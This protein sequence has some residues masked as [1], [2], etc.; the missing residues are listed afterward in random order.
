MSNQIVYQNLIQ[1]DLLY[2]GNA[3]GLTKAPSSLTPGTTPAIGAFITVDTSTVAPGGWPNGTTLDWENG[4]SA[5]YVELSPNDIIDSAFLFWGAYFGNLGSTIKD[6]PIYLITPDSIKHTITPDYALITNARSYSNVSDVTNILTGYTSGDYTVGS[7]PCA[8]SPLATDKQ[9]GGWVLALITK[10]IISAYNYATLCLTND[11]LLQIGTRIPII[12]PSNGAVTG[13]LMFAALGACATKGDALIVQNTR[14]FLITGRPVGNICCSLI[15]DNSAT[16]AINTK[17]TFGLNNNTPDTQS[18]IINGRQGLDLAIFPPNNAIPS[19]S[20]S[21]YYDAYFGN[22]AVSPTEPD[23]GYLA[24]GS[25]LSPAPG[26]TSLLKSVDKDFASHGETI[27]YTLTVS[28]TGTGTIFNL[29]LFDS[30]PSNIEV[31]SDTIYVNGVLS[32]NSK[33]DTGILLG[34]AI[35]IPYTATVSFTA[36]ILQGD[37]TTVSNNFYTVATN[38]TSNGTVFTNTVTS[39]YVTTTI[40]E[41]SVV[42]TIKYVDKSLCRSGDTITYTIEVYNLGNISIDNVILTDPLPPRTQFIPT[43]VIVDGVSKPNDTPIPPLGVNLNSINP[44]EIRT[45]TFQVLITQ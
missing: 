24:Y 28:L 5:C 3:L 37:F 32:P 8:L 25:S 23:F 42:N 6:Y 31:I 2:F 41:L 35:S 33:F 44:N 34:S 29:T 13:K 38:T 21:F 30:I 18:N 40:V 22:E 1:G 12:T 9:G 7:I 14:P 10:N 16:G 27:T 20:T 45:V 17:A 11:D 43:S 15:N 36:T 4:S 26:Y 39:G 19:G